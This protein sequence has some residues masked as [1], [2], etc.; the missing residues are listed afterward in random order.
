MGQWE[1]GFFHRKTQKLDKGNIT[2]WQLRA[3]TESVWGFEQSR[4]K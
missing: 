4:V 2:S 3:G 1:R